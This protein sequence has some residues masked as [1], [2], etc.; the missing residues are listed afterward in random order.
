MKNLSS[1]F[2]GGDY[3]PDQWPDE[4]YQED[5][6]LFKLAGINI[7]TIPVFSWALLQPSEDEYKFEWL[8]KILDLAWENGISVCLATSTAAQPSWMSKKYPEMLPVDFYGRRRKHGGRVNFCPNNEKYHEFSTKLTGLMA[9]R[10]KNHPAIALWH[11]GNEYGNYCYCDKCEEEFRNWAKK[12]Y[13]TIENL[14]KKW[15]L[16]F[17][18]HTIY[19]WDEIVI[20]SGLSEVWMDGWTAKTNFQSIAI[21]YNRF[22]SE[23]VFN[24]YKAEY[25]IIKNITPEI[26]ITTNLMGTFKPLDYF[27]WAEYMDIISWDNYPSLTDPMFKTAM[28]HDLMRGLKDGK[29]FLLMEQTPSQQNWQP[30]NSVKR[31]GVLR[32]QSYQTLAHGADAIMFFQLRQSIG[33]CE[34][35][36]GAVI[37]HAGHENT[38]VFKELTQIGDEL[39]ALGDKTIDSRMQAKVAIVFDWEN[40]WAVEFS[41]GPSKDLNYVEQV[42]KYYEAFYNMNIAVDMVKP[43]AD[44]SQYKIVVAPVLYMLRP[45]VAKNF[46]SYVENGG[47]FVTTFFSGYV[48]ETDIVKVGGYPGELRKLLG[49]WVEEIDAIFPDMSN[50]IVMKETVGKLEKEYI[51]KMLCDILNV[52]TAKVL[53][54]Y[55]KDFYAGKPA[56]TV[57]NFGKGKAYYIATDPEQSFIA[58]L[59]EVLCE[60]NS[61]TAPF[62]A[63]AG[64]EIAQRFKDDK[65]IT[66][67]M[68]YNDEDV[69]INLKDENYIDLIKNKGKKGEILI[70]SKDVLVLERKI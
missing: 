67:I 33:A 46:E 54:V 49:L 53:A 11:I 42:E 19:D 64:V 57:N 38:R 55:G 36:H 3:N 15:Y 24:C 1:I 25:D 37:S 7:I 23:S 45:G 43:E 47:T 17:W 2:Y 70:K 6:R 34:K 4:I 59:M 50:S 9:E 14:N 52:E 27:K 13:G 32:L 51:S 61:I 28:R 65:E 62:Q 39:K 21:D 18:G 44:L 40:W 60:D 41:S 8:D 69:V 66:F 35:Y 22:M 56:L 12:R 5:M 48:D 68:N 16:N 30:Y 20:P 29:P 63:K 26:P 10:Y 58:G 31:P